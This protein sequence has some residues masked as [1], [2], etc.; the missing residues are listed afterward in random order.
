MHTL[1]PLRRPKREV[2]NKLVSTLGRTIVATKG[3]FWILAPLKAR[4][5]HSPGSLRT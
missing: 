2:Y 1:Q 4:K 3:K 5:M